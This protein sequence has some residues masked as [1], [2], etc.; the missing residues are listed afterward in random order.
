MQLGFQCSEVLLKSEE[1]N[2]LFFNA[3]V[4]GI[5]IYYFSSG[6]T[7]FEA[8]TSL[9]RIGS[10]TIGIRSDIKKSYLF[11]IFNPDTKSKRQNFQK[12]LRQNNAVLRRAALSGPKPAGDRA[13]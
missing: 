8:S 1:Q 3:G 4:L 5:N 2:L 9:A 7:D 12:T 11:K 13:R 6:G 10:L